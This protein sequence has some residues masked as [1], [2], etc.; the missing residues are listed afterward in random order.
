MTKESKRKKDEVYKGMSQN[1]ERVR[2]VAQDTLSRASNIL[3][4]EC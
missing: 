3:A 1:L 4:E 2:E